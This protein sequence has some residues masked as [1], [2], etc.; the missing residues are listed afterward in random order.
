MLNL[1]VDKKGIHYLCEDG[2]E[3]L[4]LRINVCH[5][6]TSLVMPIK[7]L[8]KWCQTAIKHEVCWVITKGEPEVRVFLSY[9]H[10]LFVFMLYRQ[11][12]DV[13]RSSGVDKSSLK[14]YHW[15]TAILPQLWYGP[16]RAKT[17][18]WGVQWNDIKTL[19]LSYRQAR[20]S[21]FCS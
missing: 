12:L 21:K 15:A 16:R 1:K 13:F 18:L 4:S 20:K 17:C 11:H 5:H 2:I 7:R 6:S 14:F 10:E 19:L 8:S 3:N 9:P